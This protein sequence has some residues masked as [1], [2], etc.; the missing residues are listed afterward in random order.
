MSGPTL[1]FSFVYKSEFF[2]KVMS[3]KVPFKYTN[4][5][6]TARP[7]LDR[8]FA[9][10]LTI[11]R[12]QIFFLPKLKEFIPMHFRAQYLFKKIALLCVLELCM[13]VLLHIYSS[14][15][16]HNYFV[17][18]RNGRYVDFMNHFFVETSYY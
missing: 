18:W 3:T 8:N 14:V 13:V 11:K 1:F 9:P 7:F 12:G 17:V 16:G 2:K 5:R 6:Y 15:I 4:F 10:L